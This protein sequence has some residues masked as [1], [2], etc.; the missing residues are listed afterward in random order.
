[1]FQFSI[2]FLS[3]F[4]ADRI[5]IVTY[6]FSLHTER[7]SK[8]SAFQVIVSDS[9]DFANM[10]WDS[11]KVGNDQNHIIYSGPSL[12]SSRLYFWKVRWWDHNGDMAESLETGHFLTGVLDPSDWNNVPWIAAPSGVNSAPVFSQSA[13]I[14]PSDVKQAILSVSGLG[15]CKPFVNDVDLNAR[16]DPPIALTPGWT[17]YE[18]RVPYTVYDVT[19]EVTSVSADLC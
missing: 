11:Q 4:L 13:T 15:F 7:S 1:M 10:V 6:S 3:T 18:R 5:L 16:F 19:D 12:E 14:Y 9:S 17:N 2:L 8:Q